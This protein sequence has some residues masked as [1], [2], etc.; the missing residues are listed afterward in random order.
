MKNYD[1]I[2][3]F[4]SQETNDRKLLWEIITDCNLKCGFC[5]RST[6]NNFGASF[7]TIK[8]VTSILKEL[9][10]RKII[11]S[12]GEPFLRNDLFEILE[13]LK[14]EGFFVD[15]CT[16]ATL[17]NDEKAAKLSKLIKEVSVSID[18]Y[19]A[20]IHDDMRGVRGAFLSA[21]RGINYLIDNGIEVHST[22]L[23][24]EHNVDQIEETIKFLVNKGIKSIAFIGK[25]DIGSEKNYF[26]N[27]EIQNKLINKFKEL[28][29]KYP[30]ININTKE[31]FTNQGYTKC[32]SGEKIFSIDVDMNLRPCILRRDYL[33]VNL[34]ELLNSKEEIT[35]SF[36]LSE[37]VKSKCVIEKK[38]GICPGA[39]IMSSK[40]NNVRR[41]IYAKTCT[42]NRRNESYSS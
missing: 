24:T 38:Q 34:I 9:N 6:D 13:Y 23:L 15:L 27:D 12:G 22:T 10:I 2:C 32:L 35:E 14:G 26:N 3:C 36:I 39:K 29:E 25:I 20:K 18:S 1:S 40:K 28:R 21:L 4:S 37:M 8:S 41:D 17:I 16:N 19:D 42:D 5:H 30:N 31:I 33:G 11:I 7:E